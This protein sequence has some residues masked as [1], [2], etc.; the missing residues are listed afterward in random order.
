MEKRIQLKLIME[1]LNLDPEIAFLRD[2]LVKHVERIYSLLWGFNGPFADG[3]QLQDWLSVTLLLSNWLIEVFNNV[4]K[5]KKEYIK[6]KN[7]FDKNPARIAK[8]VCDIA[9]KIVDKDLI[10]IDG[11]AKIIAKVVLSSMT[12]VPQII[13]HLNVVLQIVEES[14]CGCMFKKNNNKQKI[15]I[16]TITKKISREC[17]GNAEMLSR[18]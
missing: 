15:K 6:V 14:C 13:K 2:H 10:Q 5:N 18:L 8:I 12:F 9:Y 7:Y 3:Y 4:N 17:R 16:Q 11:D 1:E